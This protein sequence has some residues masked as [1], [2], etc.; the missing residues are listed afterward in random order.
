MNN[1]QIADTIFNQFRMVSESINAGGCG[2]FAVALHQSLTKV[3]IESQIYELLLPERIGDRIIALTMHMIVCV[4][5]MFIDSKGKFEYEGL[6]LYY[7]KVDVKYVIESF[8]IKDWNPLFLISWGLIS[9]KE[10]IGVLS[11]EIEKALC[12]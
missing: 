6:D 10:A 5:G 8:N 11:R 4:D 2:A 1:K 9:Y 3:G 12:V 7:K